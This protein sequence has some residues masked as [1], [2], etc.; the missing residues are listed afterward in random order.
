[1]RQIHIDVGVQRGLSSTSQLIL[2]AMAPGAIGA[3]DGIKGFFEGCQRLRFVE[4]V[5]NHDSF[6][7]GSATSIRKL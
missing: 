1:M 6:D 7:V 4:T 2:G 5:R 3:K